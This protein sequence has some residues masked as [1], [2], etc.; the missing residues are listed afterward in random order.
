MYVK[1]RYRGKCVIEK[2]RKCVR[3][4]KRKCVS[5]RDRERERVRVCVLKR[6]V[7][8]SVLERE[9]EEVC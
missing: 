7:E 6:V 2:N 1:K 5:H 8:G 4:K 3:G 9:R